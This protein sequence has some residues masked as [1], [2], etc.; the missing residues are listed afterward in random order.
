MK[1]PQD[2][3]RAIAV[4][5]MIL[6]FMGDLPE[7]AHH[8]GAE[9]KGSVV[10]KIYDTFGRKSKPPKLVSLIIIAVVCHTTLIYK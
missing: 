8:E 6:R 5:I 9:R 4:F 1:N 7:P 3:H 10:K 2:R